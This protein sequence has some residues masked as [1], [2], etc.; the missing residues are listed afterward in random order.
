MCIKAKAANTKGSTKCKAKN[1][2]KVALLTEKPPH[3][4]STISCPIQGIALIRLVITVAPHRLIC[5]Y[6]STYPKKAVTIINIKIT[7][8]I[9]NTKVLGALY[10]P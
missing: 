4:N 5:P 9:L 3:M 10:D 2:F 6:G 1:L 8:P 7:T